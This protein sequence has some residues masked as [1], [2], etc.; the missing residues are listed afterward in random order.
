MVVSQ[1]R[2]I[3]ETSSP[4]IVSSNTSVSDFAD[5]LMANPEHVFGTTHPDPTVEI[6][7][8]EDYGE[9]NATAPSLVIN[10]E[11][12]YP[13]NNVSPWFSL[14]DILPHQWENKFKDFSA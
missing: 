4:Y 6:P 13:K 1:Q 8:D 3:N 2:P 14:D 12:G 5:L 7:S 9:T 10:T 11:N